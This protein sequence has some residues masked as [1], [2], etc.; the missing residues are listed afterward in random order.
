MTD[1]TPE[2]PGTGAPSS[3]PL[4]RLTQVHLGEEA[5]RRMWEG[6]ERRLTQGRGAS[7][8]R[9]HI[10][11]RWV[12]AAVVTLAL[13]AA[14]ALRWLETEAPAERAAL[15]AAGPLL[16]EDGRAFESLVAEA[17]EGARRVG[18]ADGSSIEASPG[19]RLE[20]LASTSSEFAVFLRQGRVRVSVAPHGPRRWTLETR[21]ARVEVVGTVF[22]VQTAP[23][24]VEVAVER[25][26]VLVR[27]EFLPDGVQ[28]L[29]AG[30]TVSI[31]TQAAARAKPGHAAMAEPAAQSSAMETAPSA[32]SA[33]S[34][35]AAREPQRSPSA[36]QLWEAADRARSAGDGARAAAILERV[37]EEYP[38]DAQA[39]LAAFTLGALELDQLERPAAAARSFR[40]AIQLG[41]A[42][43]LLESSHLRLGEALHRAHDVA[44]LRA[45]LE[46]YN[47]RF[48]NGRHRATLERWSR[49]TP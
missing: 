11:L 24:R 41:I 3:A 21:S 36:A 7:S 37:L 31:D 6:I 15:V 14:G 28:R 44:G 34:Q 23:D 18:F 10:E 48:P 13:G 12:L 1:E 33:R 32:D 2:A 9:R 43:S 27:S 39:P 40:R 22:S 30:A 35:P 42:G 46:Q 8:R 45:V 4:A 20:G 16:T 19:A 29:A 38:R 26:V 5:T 25:G 49:E 47:R 17:S